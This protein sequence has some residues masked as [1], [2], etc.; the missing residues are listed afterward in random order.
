[1]W[2]AY[3]DVFYDFWL[4]WVVFY[5]CHYSMFLLLFACLH[6]VISHSTVCA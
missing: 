3:K 5:N 1:M 4:G 6:I 2:Q